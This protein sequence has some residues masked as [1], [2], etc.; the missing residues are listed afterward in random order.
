MPSSFANFKQFI[1][2]LEGQKLTN[3]SGDDGGLTKYGITKKT[4][5]NLDIANLTFEQ[6]CDIYET[7]FWKHYG[8]NRI[9]SQP[10]ANKLMSFL[11]NMNP[12]SAVR[13]IQKAINQCGGNIPE[14]GILSQGTVSL[15]NRVQ[16]GW[17]LD[18]FRIEGALFY[19][20]RVRVDKTDLK[21][22]EGWI[23]RALL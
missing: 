16:S 21:F 5:P 15:I 6:A 9:D 7:D 4:Y 12:F 22:L 3:I 18:R 17:L 20:Y 14:D 8:L 2:P 1:I 11:M 23:N 10:V 13:C 19:T